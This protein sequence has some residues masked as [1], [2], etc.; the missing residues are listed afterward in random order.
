MKL[1][2]TAAALALLSAAPAPA[3]AAADPAEAELIGLER[4]SWVAWQGHDGGF[5]R[6]FLS[7][8]HIEVGYGGPTGKE[9][10][11][12]GV[13]SGVCRVASYRLDRFRFQRLDA[14]TAVLTYWAEQDTHCGTAA[15]PSPVW[16]TSL[17]QRRHGRWVN[18]L[19]EHTPAPKQG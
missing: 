9:A 13:E 3:L 17:Y 8:D 5:F 15:V 19:Y 2:L 18:V 1:A 14:H 11:A 16:A 6:G 7:D 12:K 10:V 4:A